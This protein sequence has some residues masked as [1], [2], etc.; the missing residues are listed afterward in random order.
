MHKRI[1]GK[2]HPVEVFPEPDE[3]KIPV[4]ATALVSTETAEY[5]IDNAFDTWRGPGGNRW[6]AAGAGEQT[7]ILAFDSPQTIRLI[8]P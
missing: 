1:F 7:L 2:V 3:L 5:P 6:M 4:I 8:T